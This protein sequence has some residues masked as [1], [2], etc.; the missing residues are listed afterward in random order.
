MEFD[1]LDLPRSGGYYTVERIVAEDYGFFRLN[2]YYFL[3]LFFTNSYQYKSEL[4]I[5]QIL[6]KGELVTNSTSQPIT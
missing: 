5:R 2:F 6:G 4:T 3:G 1:S